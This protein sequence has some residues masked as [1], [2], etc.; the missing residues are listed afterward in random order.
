MAS[1]GITSTRSRG[2]NPSDSTHI[3]VTYIY[4][5]AFTYYRYSEAA[6][7]SVIVFLL[8][9]GFVVFTLR[10]AVPLESKA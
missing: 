10:R 2:G 8:L 3:L 6:A 7:L 1:L 5:I 9:L 4:K